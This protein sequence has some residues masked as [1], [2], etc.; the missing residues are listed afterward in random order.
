[1]LSALTFNVCKIRLVVSFSVVPQPAT[2]P[3]LPN[4]SCMVASLSALTGGRQIGNT[5]DG[6]SNDMSP[7]VRSNARS[8]LYVSWLYLGCTIISDTL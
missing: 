4:S 2:N 5:F 6:S 8:L 1:M 7:I 3:I